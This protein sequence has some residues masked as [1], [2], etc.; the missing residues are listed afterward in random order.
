MER[1]VLI[2]GVLV[3]ASFL[4]AVLLNHSAVNEAGL[5]SNASARTP[6]ADTAPQPAPQSASSPDNPGFYAGEAG[7]TPSERAG[8]EIWY[9][10]TAG[11]SRFHTYTFQ[12]RIGVLI[13]WY[14]VLKSTERDDRF[15]AWGIIND[16]G[17]CVPG[18]DNCPAKTLEETYGFDW[19]PGDAE[20]LGYVGREGYRDPACDYSDAAADRDDP[21]NRS[22]DQRQSACDLAFGTS[23]GALGFR[24][25]PNP[26]FN[27]ERW[28]EVNK[29]LASWEGYDKRLSD[30]PANTDATATHLSDGSIEPPFLIG[31][32]CGSCHISFDPLNPPSDP[33]HPQWRNI[34]G[35]VGN[36]YT[37][38]SEILASGMPMANLEFQVFAHAR[39]GT[40]DTSAV[41]TDQINNPGTINAIINTH[42]RPTFTGE[43][44]NKW[45]KVA[46]C[47]AGATTGTGTS[48]TST[49]SADESTCWCEPGRDA[50]C[51]QRSLRTE[52]AVHHILKGGE[53][54]IGALE[55]IQRVYFNIGSCAEQCWVNHL[56]DLRQV[57]PQQRNYGQTPFNIGQCRRDCPNFRAVEDRLQNIMDFLSSRETNATDLRVARENELREKKAGARYDATA[58]LAA[59]DK[60]FGKDAVK[61]GREVFAANCARCHSSIAEKDGGPFVNRDFVALDAASGL[62]ADWMGN[63][64]STPVSEVGTSRCRALHSNH[65]AGHV[66]QEYGSETMRSRP[67]DP[68]VQE[69]GDGGR[70]YYRNI[71]LL[72]VWAHA[73]FLHDN[74]VGP[75]LC[76]KPANVANDFYRTS[77]TDGSGKLLPS[78]QSP[79][80]WAYDP[81]VTGRFK[82]FK[83]S[84]GEL[85]NPD[86]R[87]PKITK[88]SEDVPISF[89]P[90]LWDGKQ[91]R[92]VIGLSLT[93]PA[94]ASAAALGDFQHKQFVAD[95]IDSGLHRDDLRDRLNRRWGEQRGADVLTALNEIRDGILREPDRLVDEIRKRPLL[96]EV[97]SSCTA[98][99][100]N[101]GHR[102]GEGLSAADKQALTAFLA[103]L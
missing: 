68:N 15:R 7:L 12:Q 34:K 4:F 96:L 19:C 14:R 99:V 10:A 81:S 60:E 22:K 9:K 36:Q 98:T 86:Q 6:V 8:R 94:G 11:N 16:P 40:S 30:D 63:D 24:K 53:D 89:G 83:A 100:E 39:P 59:L 61:R 79:A 50:K 65:L 95:L 13:D 28:L 67:P 17:C 76:G 66:W 49:A 42:R 90:R 33:A 70:G 82:V 84:M 52:P 43:V 80:C 64:Q 23:T 73:P 74:S 44:V 37:R 26:R 1:G 75:E 56:T 41:P 47:P 18:S 58:F 91:E 103:T 69:P 72:S 57:D 51:W 21:H 31:I 46:E 32:S 92:Q 102:F 27:R 5:I 35:A 71:S 29:S 85:L 87:I 54:S 20:L 77:F 62:R 55:A 25:F 78:A 38:I 88:F 3:S 101:E 2:G 93:I 97:Y 45:R 48:T